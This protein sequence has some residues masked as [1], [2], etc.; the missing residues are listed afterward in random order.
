MQIAVKSNDLLERRQQGELFERSMRRRA[1]QSN[2]RLMRSYEQGMIDNRVFFNN[3]NKTFFEERRSNSF[4]SDTLV[5]AIN[6]NQLQV[7]RP[8]TGIRTV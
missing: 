5:K 2:E 4:P 6:H 3:T 1:V 7:W 8:T